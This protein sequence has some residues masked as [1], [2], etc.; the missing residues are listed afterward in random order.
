MAAQF[1]PKLFHTKAKAGEGEGE[2]EA[3][4]SSEDDSVLTPYFALGSQDRR[5]TGGRPPP[6]PLQ[7]QQ[8]LISR[9]AGHGGAFHRHVAVPPPSAPAPGLTVWPALPERVSAVWSASGV[10]P[11]VTTAHFFESQ[12][13]DVA[14]TPDGLALLACSTDGARTLPALRPP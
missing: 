7:Q 6:P 11:L 1:N 14:W 8:Q 10:R 4:P 9:P 12:V 2:R 5:M 3:E 13:P